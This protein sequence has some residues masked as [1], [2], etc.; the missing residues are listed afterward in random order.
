[1]KNTPFLFFNTGLNVHWG[2]MDLKPKVQTNNFYNDQ[3]ARLNVNNM[4]SILYNLKVNSNAK[5]K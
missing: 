5:E 3:N 2:I 4:T 1:M